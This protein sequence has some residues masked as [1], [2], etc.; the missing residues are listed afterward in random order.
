MSFYKS[1]ESNS[2]FI[3]NLFVSFLLHSLY[4]GKF[5]NL[6]SFNLFSKVLKILCIPKKYIEYSWE[7]IF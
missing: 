3:E 4:K 6:S 1:T 7:S 5:E 2:H